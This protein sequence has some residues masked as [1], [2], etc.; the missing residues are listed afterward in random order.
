LDARQIALKVAAIYALV[1]GLWIFFSDRLLLWFFED[2]LLLTRL[3][4]AKGMLFI[5][6]TGLLL[7]LLVRHYVSALRAEDEKR[8][9]TAE[10]LEN[11]INHIPIYVFWK[12]RELRYLGCNQRFASVAGV[13]LKDNIV[14]KTD[15]ELAWRREESDSITES[16]RRVM[17]KGKPLLEME[18][19]QLQA[20]GK[21]ATFLTSKVPLRDK[22][23]GVIGIL[24]I[25]TDITLRKRDEEALRE[26][27]E[28]I[29][30]LLDSTAE[31]IFGLDP[32]GRCTFANAACLRTLGFKSQKELLGKK[33]HELI[34]HRHSDGRN[35]SF[36][37][38]GVCQALR[39]GEGTHARGEL[40]CRSDRI[41]I[42]VEYRSLPIWREK[43][44]VGAVVTFRSLSASELGTAAS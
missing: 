21:E 42:P 23:G 4:T 35:L 6:T 9:E 32:E 8:Q 10:L 15:R 37:E 41:C 24:G 3:Q 28:K 16:D 31:A 13:G 39:T 43:K 1:A 27:E 34:S 36:E 26:S 40:F 18:E 14:G 20:D 38:C 19:K 12:D 44:L 7:F 25:F 11:V 33:V 5:A 2:P 22:N 29:R 17:L 30:L